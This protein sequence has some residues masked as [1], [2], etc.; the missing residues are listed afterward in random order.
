MMLIFVNIVRGPQVC[1]QLQAFW[2]HP[3]A[4]ESD[5]LGIV[6]YV[7]VE[8]SAKAYEPVHMNRSRTDVPKCDSRRG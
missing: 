7:Q 1:S 2:V 4:L 8:I 3:F 6:T 5:F